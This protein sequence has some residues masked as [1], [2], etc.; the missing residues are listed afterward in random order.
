MAKGSMAG[1]MMRRISSIGGM[2][3]A[4]AASIWPGG[5]GQDGAAQHLGRIGALDEA[6]RQNAG[7]QAVDVDGSIA[8][9]PGAPG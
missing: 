2:P 4:R 9:R 7:Q 5:I 8:A 1:K 6:Q 3:K